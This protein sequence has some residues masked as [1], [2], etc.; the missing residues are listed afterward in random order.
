MVQNLFVPSK[1]KAIET[2]NKNKTNTKVHVVQVLEKHTGGLAEIESPQR[3]QARLIM[4]NLEGEFPHIAEIKSKVGYIEN[5]T[6]RRRFKFFINFTFL[7][8]RR[9]Y[10]RLGK[11][12]R[13]VGAVPEMRIIRYSSFLCTPSILFISMVCI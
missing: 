11:D 1:I 4:W 7:I 5:F 12:S 3:I 9:I 13:M 2:H 8:M 6:S 10:L